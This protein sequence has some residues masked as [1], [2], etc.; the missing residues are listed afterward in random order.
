MFKKIALLALMLAAFSGSL[1]AQSRFGHINSSEVVGMMSDTKKADED[2]KK[3]TSDLQ[4]QLKAMVEELQNKYQD[5]QAKK[6]SLADAVK[7][8]REKEIQDL[9]Q[10][11]DDFQQSAQQNI[12]KKKEELYS[13]IFKKVEKAIKE[14]AAEG[15]YAYIFDSSTGTVLYAQDSDNILDLVKKKLNLTGM[16][17]APADEKPKTPRK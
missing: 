12:G 4:T 8:I 13:P 17:A 1:M 14:V 7:E 10:R 3:F 15:K 2:L 16:P 9:Q 11:I 5:Y 6:A